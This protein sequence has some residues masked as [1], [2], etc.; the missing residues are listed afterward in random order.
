MITVLGFGQVAFAAPTDNRPDAPGLAIAAEHMPV[1]P[2][3]ASQTAR[4]HARVIVNKNGKPQTITTPD[5]YG[6]AQLLGAYNLSGIAPSQQII[7]IVDAY[8]HPSIQSDLDTYSAKF[9]IPSLPAC[10]GP[11]ASSEM[12]CFQKVDQNGGTNYPVTNA[13]WA[14]EI[15]LDVETAHAVC[16]NCSILLV[17]AASA[18]LADLATA[19]DT[20]VT[21]GANEVS[22]SYGASE[23]AGE[24]SFDSHYNHPGVAVTV[25]AGDSGFGVQFPAASPFVTSVGGTSLYLNSDNTYNRESAWSNTGSGCSSVEMI[26]PLG[27]PPVSNCSSRTVSDVSAVAD[28][29]TGAAVYSSV[30][31]N[32][33]SGWF[34]VGGTSL[35]APLIAAVYALAGGVPSGVQGNTIPYAHASSLHDVTSGSNGSCGSTGKGKN[36]IVSA[37]CNA[38]AGFDGP[39]GLGTPNGIGA[40]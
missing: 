14:L 25:S 34:K 19:V 12:P 37:L 31:Y 9:G 40:F 29:N 22:N 18:S 30:S 3:G 15:A 20:A 23:F 8:D 7:A 33:A 17:E 6:P 2:P 21:L 38:V 1:C 26:K 11:V 24:T 16:Q 39:T 32:G 27:Q 36:A 28:P 10:T 5:A 35:A 13:G 4:C